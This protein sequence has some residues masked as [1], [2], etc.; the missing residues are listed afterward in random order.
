MTLEEHMHNVTSSLIAIHADIAPHGT[1]LPYGTYQIIDGQSVV[2]VDKSTP[3]KKHAYVQINIYAESALEASNLI[4]QVEKR[5]LETKDFNASPINA[6]R[7]IISDDP[8]AKIKGR[9]QDFT[10]WYPTK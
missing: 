1:P 8:D 6:A 10:I 7:S 5:L 4:A 2:F 3:D 9:M